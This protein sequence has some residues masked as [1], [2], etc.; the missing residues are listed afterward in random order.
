LNDEV[1]FS[2]IRGR[3]PRG[4]LGKLERIEERRLLSGACFTRLL[5]ARRMQNEKEVSTI[6]DPLPPSIEQN[7]RLSFQERCSFHDTLGCSTACP[8]GSSVLC[9]S[10]QHRHVCHEK[11]YHT[12]PLQ[13]ITLSNIEPCNRAGNR[14]PST[15]GSSG[16]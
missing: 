5:G 8:S 14:H 15:L 13:R 3:P 11:T 7:V 6:A 16:I 2:S 12:I 1:Q 4:E 9:T 10:L